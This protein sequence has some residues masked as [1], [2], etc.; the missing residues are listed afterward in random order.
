MV[1]LRHK[2][3]WRQVLVVVVYLA[4]VLSMYF[5]PA[6][7]NVVCLALACTFSFYAMTVNHNVMHLSLFNDTAANR[8]FRLVL[9]FC[10]L[11][12]VSSLIPSHNLVHHH[13]NDD[14]ELDWADPKHARFSWNLLNLLHF[15]NIIGPITFSHISRWARVTGRADY[16]AASTQESIFAFGL[17]GVLLYFDFWGALFYV[18]V[19]QLWGARW[20]LRVNIIQHDGCDLGSQWNHSRN[21]AGRLLNWFSVNAGYHTIHH[22]RPS[23]HWSELPEAHAREATG[24]M[25][26]ALMEKSLLWYLARTYLFRFSRPRPMDVG[27]SERAAP[28]GPVPGEPEPSGESLVPPAVTT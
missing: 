2:H 18:V 26:P 7:R 11:F 14:G 23:L 25:H 15:P 27:V 4:L 28:L 3:D 5:E 16:R 22:N 8:L 17:T 10:A 19:P 20:F 1:A 6:C 21:F 13:F 24:K 12:P 9:S